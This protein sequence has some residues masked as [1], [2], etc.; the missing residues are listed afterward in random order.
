MLSDDG[1]AAAERRR[2]GRAFGGRSS[3]G[4]RR[5]LRSATSHTSPHFAP[6]SLQ[7]LI[8]P[9]PP[10][11]LLIPTLHGRFHEKG[12]KFGFGSPSFFP[13]RPARAML[14]QR[15]QQPCS[16]AVRG[17]TR[18]RT[19]VAVLSPPPPGQRPRPK[20]KPGGAGGAPSSSPPSSPPPPPPATAAP[21]PAIKLL[22]ELRA[23]TFQS[24]LE[25]TLEQQQDAAR[26]AA[27][28]SGARSG[29]A[30]RRGGGSPPL[31]QDATTSLSSDDDE[32]PS[33]VD[34]AAQEGDS[35]LPRLPSSR[36]PASVALLSSSRSSSSPAAALSHAPPSPSSAPASPPPPPLAEPSDTA[37]LYFAFG[38]NMSAAT[39]RRRGV[40]EVYGH[41]PAFVE[42]PA[43][44][45]CF[46][47]RGGYATLRG[48]RLLAPGW[49]GVG[50]GK[51]RNEREDA[52]SPRGISPSRVGVLGALQADD[53]GERAPSA[54][55]A[56]AASAAGAGAHPSHVH[57]VLYRLSK[58]DLGRLAGAEGGYSLMEVDV[59]TYGGRR[60]T[61][62]SFV[63]GAMATLHAEVKPTERYLSA[64]REGA[65]DHHLDPVWQAWLSGLETVPSAGLGPEY[66]D[67]P[68]KHLATGFLV[69]VAVGVAL[70]AAHSYAP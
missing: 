15:A 46:R 42:D 65:A 29:A 40:Y 30:R 63:S 5:A 62:L 66:F 59:V 1:G 19:V 3:S 10:C 56:A 12:R 68:S 43:T 16:V 36:S 2:L 25:R 7:A 18:V 47:H 17:R 33:Y 58:A 44:R 27:R 34:E 54:A 28:Q 37:V 26:R 64:L 14:Q 52:A 50:G 53:A 22:E 8:A 9:L 20:S 61:A 70:W 13:E 31:P 67:A 21:A 11:P 60:A 38:A 55:A 32:Y 45:L 39:L 48:G 4:E 69:A 51:S 6:L 23:L 24:T 41:E 35:L 57:G 49:A